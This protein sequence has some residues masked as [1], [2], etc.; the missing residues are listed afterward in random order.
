[1]FS[2]TDCLQIQQKGLTIDIVNEQIRFFNK[3]VPF[4][5]IFKPAAYGDGVLMLN[6]ADIQKY[7]AEYE[8][9]KQGK[10]IIKFVP[11]SGAATRMFKALYEYISKPSSSIIADDVAQAINKIKSFA[12]YNDL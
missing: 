7:I 8:T 9:Q 4:L 3:G 12:F 11:A 10:K 2:P 1:M 6:D 5:N